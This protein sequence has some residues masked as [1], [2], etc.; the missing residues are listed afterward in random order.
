VNEE[1][2]DYVFDES[3]KIDFIKH[4]A[5]ASAIPKVDHLPVQKSEAEKKS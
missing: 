1:E 5:A 2:F 3:V 4:A